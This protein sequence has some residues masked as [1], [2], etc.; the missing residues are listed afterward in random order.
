MLCFALFA[1]CSPARCPPPQ[2]LG[3]KSKILSA[4]LRDIGITDFTEP[5]GGYFVWAKVRGSSGSL[6]WAEVRGSGGSLVWAEV[7]GSSSSLVWAK[8]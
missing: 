2:E 5:S 6:V 4:K 1:H 8:V 7:R 3:K